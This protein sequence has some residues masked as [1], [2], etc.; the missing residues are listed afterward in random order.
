MPIGVLLTLLATLCIHLAVL[1]HRWPVVTC[2]E[3]SCGQ[4]ST[5]DVTS[6]YPFMELGH[7]SCTFF[8]VH[9]FQEWVREPK[10]IQLAIN[11]CELAG[12]LLY[13]PS[14]HRIQREKNVCQA[15]LVLCYPRVWLMCSADLR[16][17]HPLPSTCSYSRRSQGLL[18]QR[19]VTPRR[20]LRRLAYLKN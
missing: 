13:L 11:H 16:H 17:V 18:G 4:S 19:P 9:T 15:S 1:P 6:T 2:T 5:P 14:L 8:S 10:P 20:F 12:V 7:N 3:D